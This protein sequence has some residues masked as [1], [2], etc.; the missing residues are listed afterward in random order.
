MQGKHTL[1]PSGHE[2]INKSSILLYKLH[3][4]TEYYCY[5]TNGATT[6]CILFSLQ[7]GSAW[8]WIFLSPLLFL[9]EVYFALKASTSPL[10]SYILVADGFDKPEKQEYVHRPFLKDAWMP[11]YL[12]PRTLKLLPESRAFYEKSDW[13][14][15]TRWMRFW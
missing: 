2:G 14:N 10:K 5:D 8:V 3:V 11:V 13:Q 9:I 1:A 6:N 4:A 7:L 15:R 12:K